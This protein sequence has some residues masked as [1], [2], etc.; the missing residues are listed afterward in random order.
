MELSG[1]EENASISFCIGSSGL[2]YAFF[3]L[4]QS[5]SHRRATS[6]FSQVFPTSGRVRKRRRF[7]KR[8]K[9][10]GAEKIQNAEQRMEPHFASSAILRLF[11]Y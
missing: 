1:K 6:A 8:L 3:R 9:R 10:E 7:G 4:V 5:M 2:P 11:L